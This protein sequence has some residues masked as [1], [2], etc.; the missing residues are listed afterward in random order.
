MQ[1]VSHEHSHDLDDLVVDW[2]T[3]CRGSFGEAMQ[4]AIPTSSLASEIGLKSQDP[5]NQ[6]VLG[7]GEFIEITPLRY[8]RMAR[9][10]RLSPFAAVWP[11]K[12]PAVEDDYNQP[13]VPARLIYQ[14]LDPLDNCIRYALSYHW[15]ESSRHDQIFLN[16]YFRKVTKN[17]AI[18]LRQLYDLQRNSKLRRG[19]YI[20]I[21]ALCL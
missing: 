14:E 11:G 10:S 7:P 5:Q 15:G 2:S 16:G 6:N 12:G 9:N 8:P 19:S 3:T 17:L 21:D 1:K 18:A 13:D 4:V 20:W